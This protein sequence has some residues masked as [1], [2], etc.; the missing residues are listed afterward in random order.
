MFKGSF[1]FCNLGDKYKL[2][3][4]LL[5]INTCQLHR[6][7]ASTAGVASTSGVSGYHR[8]PSQTPYR[9]CSSISRIRVCA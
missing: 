9:N 6:F 4:E 1:V 7:A 3:L 2:K 8:T 5:L